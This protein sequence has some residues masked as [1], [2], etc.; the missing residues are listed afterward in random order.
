MGIISIY[1]NFIALL[2]SIPE[3]SIDG[4]TSIATERINI[5]IFIGIIIHEN[6][7]GTLFM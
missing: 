4:T 5:I 7:I 2:G 1:S 3:I 6:S